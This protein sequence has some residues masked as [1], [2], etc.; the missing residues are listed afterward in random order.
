MTISRK[1]LLIEDEREQ[2]QV[3]HSLFEGQGYQTIS[4]TLAETALSQPPTFLPDV[5]ITDVKLPG[6]DG[7]TFFEEVRSNERYR[8][9][10]FI[11]ITGYNDPKAINHLTQMEAV[12][13]LTKPYEIE[14]L[15][16][17]VH[18]TFSNEQGAG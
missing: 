15:L 3:L 13:Y 8:H 17:L 4:T 16:E 11:F 7:F 6:K 1:V 14:S 5:I 2:R 10:P 12:K 18:Q 9:I